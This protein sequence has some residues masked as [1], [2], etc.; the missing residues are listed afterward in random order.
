[1]VSAKD[2]VSKLLLQPTSYCA[3]KINRKNA[4]NILQLSVKK[5][6]RFSAGYI[7]ILMNLYNIHC[8]YKGGGNKRED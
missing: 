5:N 2:T 1:M 4:H 6:P 3:M 8:L 7:N